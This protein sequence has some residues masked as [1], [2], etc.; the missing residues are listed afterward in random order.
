[1]VLLLELKME[2]ARGQ[3]SLTSLLRLPQ[4]II[5]VLKVQLIF[6]SII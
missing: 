5:R 6:L 1:M 4:L 2:R 3:S